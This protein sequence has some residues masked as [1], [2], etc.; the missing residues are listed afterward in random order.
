MFTTIE[1]GLEVYKE[2]LKA[3]WAYYLERFKK[4]ES[5]TETELVEFNGDLA[6][7]KGMVTVLG[8]SKDEEVSFLEEVLYEIKPKS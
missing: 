1:Q 3:C 5:P 7:L 4:Q 8:L 6:A 2:K